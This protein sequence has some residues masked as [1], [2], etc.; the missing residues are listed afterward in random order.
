MKRG[1]EGTGAVLVARYECP[2]CKKS[3]AVTSPGRTIGYFV[4]VG[5]FGVLGGVAVALNP[6]A[7]GTAMAVFCGVA[8]GLI[9]VRGLFAVRSLV[10]H[11]VA[12]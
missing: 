7:I 11:P 12:S 8:G 6:S 1:R 9:L 10:K 5:L 4:G 3:F 2:A